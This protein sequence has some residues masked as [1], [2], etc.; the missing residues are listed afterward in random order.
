[1][2]INNIRFKFL[3]EIQ[4]LPIDTFYGAFETEEVTASSF[5]FEKDESPSMIEL[6][7]FKIRGN[8]LIP[9]KN[10]VPTFFDCSGYAT[11]GLAIF[12]VSLMDLPVGDSYVSIMKIGASGIPSKDYVKSVTWVKK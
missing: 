5:S 8:H 2:R 9:V 6:A 12:D 11:S 7:I 1:M 10:D 3:D 4:D